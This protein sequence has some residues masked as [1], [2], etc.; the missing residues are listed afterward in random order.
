MAIVDLSYTQGRCS[1][2]LFDLLV[3]METAIRFIHGRFYP[4]DA[5]VMHRCPGRLGA[6]VF[7][8]CVHCP[9]LACGLVVF[10]SLW[11]IP[12]TQI[13]ATVEPFTILRFVPL[14]TRLYPCVGR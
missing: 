9:V 8:R 11:G 12:S 10:F 3:R 1:G 14:S 13:D 4:R 2:S 7:S 6:G 5:C